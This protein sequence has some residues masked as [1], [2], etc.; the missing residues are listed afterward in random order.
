MTERVGVLLTDRPE[1]IVGSPLVDLFLKEDVGS[2]AG[3][4]L[5]FMLTKQSRFEN[6]IVRAAFV[7]EHRLWSLSGT[8]QFEASGQFAGYRG[9]GIDIT[10]QRKSSDHVSRLAMYDALTGLPNRCA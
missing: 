10:E 9:G 3:R 1:D 8:P 6:L 4:N 7:T 5:P 2:G